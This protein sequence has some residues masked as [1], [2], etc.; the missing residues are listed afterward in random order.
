MSATYDNVRYD[1]HTLPLQNYFG[2]YKM[3]ERGGYILISLVTWKHFKAA[4]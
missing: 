4:A 2:W 3:D 1:K